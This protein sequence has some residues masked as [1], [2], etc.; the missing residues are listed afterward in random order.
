MYVE[1]TLRSLILLTAW[2]GVCACAS[3]MEQ[4]TLERDGREIRVEGRVVVEAEDGGLML[5]G[6][7]GT[8]WTIPPDEQV[9]RA[10]DD[11]EFTP[12]SRD[13]LAE[14]IL[15]ELPSGFKVHETAHYLIC[16]NTSRAYAQWC[17]SLFERLHMAFSNYW[18][19]KG[20]ELPEP[21][22]PLVAIV[23]S[24]QRAYV[25]HA[26]REVGDVARSI[27][28]YFSLRTNRMTMFDLSGI[29]SVG[30]GGS[31]RGSTAQINRI[32][33][34]PQAASTVATIVHEATHQIAYN[35]GLHARHSDCPL[36]FSEGI[37]VYF[38][39][40]DLRSSKSWGNIGAV[41]RPRLTRFWSYLA[42]RPDDSLVTLLSQ[43]DRFRNTDTALDAYAETWALTYFLIRQRGKQ[44][45]E[46]LR[47]ISG[48]KPLLW[49]K[50]ETRLNEFQQAFGDLRELDKEFL[51]YMRRVR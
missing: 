7:D 41:N 21:E 32:L 30:Q 12:F 42:R 9:R 44:Y 13:E 37:A 49:D 24:D 23:F 31:R 17:G 20:F 34:Q 8:L 50:P 39:T 11:T 47:K 35:R 15:G 45:T 38:E 29:S 25:K 36:W 5:L 46:Y 26:Q 10:S 14:R 6:R 43:D 18:T 27:S 33:A 2:L 19:R 22:F 4:V 28:G 1:R 51:R 48:K 3:G 16:H 40:P